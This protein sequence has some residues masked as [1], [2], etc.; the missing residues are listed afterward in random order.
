M[1]KR[2]VKGLLALVL[3]GLVAACT[4][5]KPAETVCEPGVEDL[6]RMGDLTPAC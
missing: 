3:L 1:E 5:P 4:Q 2:V 6:S